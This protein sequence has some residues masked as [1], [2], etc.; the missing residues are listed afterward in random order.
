M[1][2][3][4]SNPSEVQTVIPTIQSQA[5]RLDI[6]INNAAI[7]CHY[8]CTN[9]QTNFWNKVLEVNL[10]API[11]LTLAALPL[12]EI[13]SG[14]IINIS[15]M[16]GLMVPPKEMIYS[17]GKFGLS[18][19]SEGLSLEL[20]HKKT[21]C[22]VI[23]VG[24]IDTPIWDKMQQQDGVGYRGKKY[25]PTIVSKAV[26]RCLRTRQQSCFA[27]KSMRAVIMFKRCFPKIFR[28]LLLNW[29]H[30]NTI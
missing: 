21:S 29:E 12:L 4:L 23:Y 24:A 22:S 15:S 6:L 8:A 16:A 14:H 19:L 13:N 20:E 28:R 5:G 7:P 18:A 11:A 30:A 1:V 9:L 26:L 17:A 27:P 3:D 10:R 25:S 2:I